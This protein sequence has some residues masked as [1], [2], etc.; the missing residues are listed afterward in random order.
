MISYS[1]AEDNFGGSV[2]K[3]L[4]G[5]IAGPWFLVRI[6]ALPLSHF[7]SDFSQPNTHQSVVVCEGI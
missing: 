2:P 7:L 4:R 5:R 6:Q 1:M 3:W